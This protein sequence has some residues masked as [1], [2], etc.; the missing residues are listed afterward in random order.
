MCTIREWAR[1]DLQVEVSRHLLE[2]KVLTF[3]LFVSQAKA[4]DVCDNRF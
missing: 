3:S 2:L 4:I 1:G